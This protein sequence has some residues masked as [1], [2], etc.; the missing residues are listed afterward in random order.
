MLRYTLYPLYRLRR[1]I[2]LSVA[3]LFVAIALSAAISPPS[4]GWRVPEIVGG[5]FAGYLAMLLAFWILLPNAALQ[6]LLITT[7][8]GIM[9]VSF[10]IQDWIETLAPPGSPLTDELELLSTAA[11]AMGVALV[12]A[13]SFLGLLA[14]VLPKTTGPKIST[15][16]VPGLSPEAC[17]ETMRPEP[18]TRGGNVSCSAADAEGW[19]D[20]SMHIRGPMNW[21]GAIGD[22]TF[23]YRVR[24]AEI[25]PGRFTLEIDQPQFPRNS[26]T[27]AVTPEGDGCRITTRHEVFIA[28]LSRAAYW[29]S[30][31]G[32]DQIIARFDT[33]RGGRNPAICLRPMCGVFYPLWRPFGWLLGKIF[34]PKPKPSETLPDVFS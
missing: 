12:A 13:L 34:P 22:A 5:V 20:C 11:F 15:L 24:V 33:W 14:Q 27:L 16:F 9:T 28:P 4:S 2:A 18:D 10:G 31:A 8:A 3:A 32:P 6:A 30:D 29:L 26:Y 19:M 17:L 1:V 7:S 21:T 25:A 23:D